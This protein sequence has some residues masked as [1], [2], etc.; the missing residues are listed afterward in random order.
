MPKKL[1]PRKRRISFVK[2][3]QEIKTVG[4]YLFGEPDSDPSQVG[5]QCFDLILR[6]ARK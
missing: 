4:E 5:E 1:E 3:V 2:G 6:E